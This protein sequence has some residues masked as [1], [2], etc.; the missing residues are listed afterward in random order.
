MKSNLYW[1]CFNEGKAGKD[2]DSRGY[3][4]HSNEY[5]DCFEGWLAGYASVNPF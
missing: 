5:I 2:F 1:T 3:Y 4:R